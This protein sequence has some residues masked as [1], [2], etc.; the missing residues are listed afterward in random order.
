M[1]RLLRLT[2]PRSAL[3]AAE[4]ILGALGG[5]VWAETADERDPVAFEAI[6]PPDLPEERVEAALLALVEATGIAA[7]E[8]L[9][10]TLAERDWVAESQRALPPEEIGS[11]FVHGSHVTSRPPPALI[12]LLIDANQAFGTGRHESTRGCLEALS[13]LAEDRR[14]ARVLDLGC[15]SGVLALGAA[16]LWPEARVLAADNDPIA[17]RVASENAR[18]NGAAET[19]ATLVSD[20]FADPALAEAA[21][22]DLILANILAEPLIALA[23]GFAAHLA[24]GGLLVLAGLLAKEGPAVE[25]AQSAAGLRPLTS[26]DLAEWRILVMERP[27][28]GR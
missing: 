22:F 28:A 11:F 20:G 4:E 25:A 21:P 9:F 18:L 23:P 3:P 8:V 16:K 26:H 1:T 17:I 2:L 19:I 5:A 27:A 7:S 13:R 12:P 14:F 6:L 10:E 24:P 15:G